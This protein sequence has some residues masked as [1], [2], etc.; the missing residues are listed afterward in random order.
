M[1]QIIPYLLILAFLFCAC[2]KN[3][4][5]ED[6]GDREWVLN[7]V[8]S[9]GKQAFVYFANTR[10][11]LDSSNNQPVD[12]A[13]LTLT[14][15]GQPY[16]PVSEVRCRYYFPHI[17]QENDSLA[18]DIVAGDRRVHAE[19]Y[20]PPVPDIRGFQPRKFASSS[21]NFYTVDFR[22]TDHANRKE[23]YNV[24]VSVRDSGMRYNAWGD[25]LE[26]VDTVR[27]TYFLVPYNPE[28]T[29]NEVNPYIPLGGY[30]YSRIMFTDDLI[31]GQRDPIAL[32]IINT[33]D[34][35]ERAPFKHEYFVQVESVTPARWNYI[36]SSSQQAGS[37][38]LFAEQGS[39]WTNVEGAYGIFAGT[40][41]VRFAFDPDTLSPATMPSAM[42]RTLPTG[43]HTTPP[44]KML[45]Y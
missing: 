12:G 22:L 7:G 2:E 18:I 43:Q 24:T 26:Y 4:E 28:I 20:L 38:S 29:S 39:V 17:L 27:Q 30:L 6:G 31:D 21:F 11:F 5:I 33:V 41:N 40:S 25:S 45:I 10:F 34:T 23:Y 32:Y 15:N 42:P 35:N 44:A 16:S 14:V 8:P 1:K 13:T 19:T 3:V 37:F 9:T 36:I